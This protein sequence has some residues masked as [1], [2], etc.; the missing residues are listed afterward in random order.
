MGTGK[1][2]VGQIVAQKLGREFVDVDAVIETREGKTVRE[3]FA[4]RGEAYFRARES[5]VCAE[6]APRDAERLVIA[7][8]G[9]ALVNPQNRA[10]FARAFVVCLDASVDAILARL[11]LRGTGERPLL[12]GNDTHASVEALLN[13]RREQYAQIAIH[14]DTTSKSPVQV[15]D[16]IIAQMKSK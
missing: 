10:A 14:V 9:G 2:S 6:L 4:T 13:A 12:V 1:T 5:A 7:T 15:A 16:E 3:L 8:G 11:A